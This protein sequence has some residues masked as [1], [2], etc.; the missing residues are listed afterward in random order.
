[1]VL[2]LRHVVRPGDVIIIEE[3]EAHLHPEMQVEFTRQL[4]AAVRAGVRVI[5]TTHSEWILEE[6]ANLARISELSEAECKDIS[7]GIALEPHEV[8]AWLFQPKERPN[9]SVV[10]E[11]PLDVE[12]G[13]FAAGYDD[14]A[15]ALHNRWADIESRLKARQ[16]R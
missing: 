12:S 14:V 9:G 4:A 15:A 3:P 10:Q 5:A 13:T 7:G 1:M 6:L 2:Y 11:I 16:R 8:G